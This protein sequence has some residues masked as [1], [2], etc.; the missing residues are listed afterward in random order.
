MK[1]QAFLKELRKAGCI[2]Y[3][4]GSRHDLYLNPAN[5]R[6][7]PVPRHKEIKNSLCRIIRKQ[8]GLEDR[9]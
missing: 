3:R 7:A 9:P 1:L 4:H 6:K 5:G 2:L 8:L